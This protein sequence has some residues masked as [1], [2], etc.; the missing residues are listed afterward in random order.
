MKN[1]K[2]FVRITNQDIYAEIKGLRTDLGTLR[3]HNDKA[4]GIILTK[5]MNNQAEIKVI[6]WISASALGIAVFISALLITGVS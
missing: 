4:H 5:H 6:R 1:G 2:T 3:E